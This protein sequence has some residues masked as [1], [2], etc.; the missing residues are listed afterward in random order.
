MLLDW[1][2]AV[3]NG[4]S[5]YHRDR[6]RQWLALEAREEEEKSQPRRNVHG[7]RQGRDFAGAHTGEV[8]GGAKECVEHGCGLCPRRRKQ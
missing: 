1:V 2:G 4:A 7:V 5:S 6:H 8:H 3:S